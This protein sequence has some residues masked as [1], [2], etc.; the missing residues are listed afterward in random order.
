MG[1]ASSWAFCRRVL[2]L[3]GKNLPETNNESFPWHL[4]G[5][6]FRLQWKPLMP[7]EPPDVSNLPPS[8]YA[9]FLI[10]TA[11]F[12]LGPLASLIDET[13]F[14]RHIRELYED[15]SAK[16]SSCKLWY[17]QYLLMLAFGK[18]FL[19]GRN[20]DG[21]PPGYQ[22][23]ARAMQLMPELAGIA[24]DPVLSAQALTLA[25][26]YFQSI[27]MRVAAFQHVRATLIS[28][29]WDHG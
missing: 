15:A 11:R 6:A 8:D 27:D 12:Y 20:P 10:Q 17:A 9:L 21:S 29:L 24:L 26:I 2:A 23:A 22:Y 5:V 1:P 4:D 25:A 18:A 3:L 14:I 19:S 28:D 13:E 16:A 7:D